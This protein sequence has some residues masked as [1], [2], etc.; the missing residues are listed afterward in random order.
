[1]GRPPVDV[2]AFRH[3]AREWLARHAAEAPPDY[4][5]IFPS[6]GKE[7]AVAWQR[8]LFGAGLAGLH[9]PV[10][11]G[12]QGLSPAHT[13]VWLEECAGA[14]VPPFL[15]MV[16]LVLTAEGLLRFGTPEQQREHLPPLARGERVWCQLFSEPGSG[17]DLASLTTQARRDGNAYLLAGQKIWCSNGHDADWGICLARTDPDE[18]GHRGLS[19]F[20]VDMH[21]PGVT[22]RPIRQMTGA[23]DF[24]GVW[25]D[26]VRLPASS[27]LGEEGA[28][29][30]IAMATLTAER[31]HVGAL[32]TALRVRL[33]RL[34]TDTGA[35]ADGARRDELFR[36]WCRG[37]AL[38]ALGDRRESL[39]P[40]AASLLKLGASEL[41]FDLAMFE[42]A[43]AGAAGLL[44]GPRTSAALSAPG[45]RIA[46]GSTQVQKNIL[47][48]RVLGLPR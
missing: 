12:G 11:L 19:F 39:G 35:R 9:W 31:G 43:L 21:A 13:A 27:L 7:Q 20:L 26:G 10:D 2:D 30:A 22:V 14:R 47:A 44:T 23:A 1:M 17:S 37:R 41:A 15:N 25:F 36:L 6:A 34:V 38:V 8:R 28:G 45:G 5:A 4:G 18:P 42:Q 32:A 16:G 29:W 40:L 33:D 24:D 46:G 48:E 3:H